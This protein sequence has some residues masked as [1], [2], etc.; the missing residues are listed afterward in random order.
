MSAPS[1][2]SVPSTSRH[3]E[4]RRKGFLFREWDVANPFQGRLIYS[5]WWFR[6]QVTLDGEPLYFAIS[7][8]TI[9]PRLVFEL[10]PS[11]QLDPQWRSNN[12]ESQADTLDPSIG[13]ESRDDKA[14]NP[15]RL[16]FEIDFTRGLRIRRFRIWLAGRL[17]F[18]EFD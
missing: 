17:L 15:R 18:D 10:P 16:E 8:L 4:L 1:E 11:I 14:S 9:R 3:A 2:E 5:G 12:A 13:S 6:Q 7:W